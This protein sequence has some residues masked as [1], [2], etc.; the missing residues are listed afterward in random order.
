MFLIDET[1]AT[2]ENLAASK[3]MNGNFT[4]AVELLRKALRIREETSAFEIE[5]DE[6]R[7]RNMTNLAGEM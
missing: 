2:I 6:K 4:E 5:K 7:L 3:Y 1:L